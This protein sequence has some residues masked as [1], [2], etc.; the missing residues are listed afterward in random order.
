M[1][2]MDLDL[3]LRQHPK[4]WT[5]PSGKRGSSSARSSSPRPPHPPYSEVSAF[6]SLGLKGS[7]PQ[8]NRDVANTSRRKEE[9]LELL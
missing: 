3:P 5:P 2:E 6:E 1:C 8:T 9:L 7:T 4:G